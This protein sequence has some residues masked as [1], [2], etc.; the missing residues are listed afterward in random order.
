MKGKVLSEGIKG[1]CDSK[2]LFVEVWSFCNQ[3][4][5]DHVISFKSQS[6]NNSLW[7]MEWD[8]R[9]IVR[10]CLRVYTYM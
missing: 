4:P 6:K 5:S 3:Q 2:N 8:M 9:S 10:A 1:H 7:I